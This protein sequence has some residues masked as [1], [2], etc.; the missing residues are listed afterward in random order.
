MKHFWI[1]GKIEWA[2]LNVSAYSN[3]NGA[4]ADTTEIPNGR[5]LK[6]VLT[7]SFDTESGEFTPNTWD[8][9][10]I[11][12]RAS[13]RSFVLFKDATPVGWATF[14]TDHDYIP[15]TDDDSVEDEN[16]G[17]TDADAPIEE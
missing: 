2:T 8:N 14:H 11:V 12:Q 3:R 6:V 16:E 17:E 7:N 4:F 5:K 13:R 15:P 1:K 9:L 10:K